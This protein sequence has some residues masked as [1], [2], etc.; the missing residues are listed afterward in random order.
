MRKLL[1]FVAVASMLGGPARADSTTLSAPYAAGDTVTQCQFLA[2][3]IDPN[4]C[5]MS[6][7]PDPET[8][9]IELDAEIASPDTPAG[10]HT[11]PTW[12]QA[13]TY[14]AVYGGYH[15]TVPAEEISFT[16]TWHISEMHFV[17]D[18]APQL[19]WNNVVASAHAE[20]VECRCSKG[21]ASVTLSPTMTGTT[22]VA[23]I[24]IR[25]SVRVTTGP[26]GEQH[27]ESSPIPAG[28]IVIKA[29]FEV[30]AGLLA[31]AGR[32]GT[33]LRGEVPSIAVQQVDAPPPPPEG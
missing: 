17:A 25:G 5:T 18:G 8:G 32:A 30:Q 3:Q 9:A 6:A 24:T 28:T 21:D 1:I 14:A 4:A 26:D 15:V 2:P 19:V 10:A 7:V 31:T 20:H 23:T 33:S 12:G 16:F 22:I 11:A 13:V 29:G 27:V